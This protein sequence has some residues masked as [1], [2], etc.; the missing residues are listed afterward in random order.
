MSITLTLQ[1][2]DDLAAVLGAPDRD[3]SR[4]ALEALAVEEYRAGRL[5][6][7][8]FRRLLDISRFEADGIL[9]AH[10]VWLDYTLADFEREGEALNRLRRPS[11]S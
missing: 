8:Q 4:T 9:K 11:G 1:L 7:L 6:D 2:P 5:S 3:L 10:G